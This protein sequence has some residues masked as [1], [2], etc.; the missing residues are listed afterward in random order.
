MG[1]LGLKCQIAMENDYTVKIPLTT[2]EF[3]RTGNL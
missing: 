1:K 3:E 2:P